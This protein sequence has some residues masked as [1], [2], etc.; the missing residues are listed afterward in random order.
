MILKIIIMFLN[1][2]LKKINGEKSNEELN[3]NIEIY[4]RIL[5]IVEFIY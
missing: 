1:L 4:K 3:L 2:F 5:F